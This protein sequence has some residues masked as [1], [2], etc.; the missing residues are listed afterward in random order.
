[1]AG[2]AE[3]ETSPYHDLPSYFEALE[4]AGKVVVGRCLDLRSTSYEDAATGASSGAHGNRN[5]SLL[6][7]ALFPRV[8]AS[9]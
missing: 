5:F 9:K 7:E 8:I 1:M 3:I 4:V 2:A 6:F